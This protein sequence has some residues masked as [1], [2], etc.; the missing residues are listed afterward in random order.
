[1]SLIRVRR[2]P[3][4]LILQ[5]DT[6]I[7]FPADLSRVNRVAAYYLMAT[8]FYAIIWSVTRNMSEEIM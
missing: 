2:G 1:M 3:R 6:D 8:S 7:R 5:S 4:H